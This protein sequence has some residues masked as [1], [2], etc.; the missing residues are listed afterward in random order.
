MARS[1][2]RNQFFSRYKEFISLDRNGKGTK[3][4][5]DDVIKKSRG[6]VRTVAKDTTLRAPELTAAAQKG[7]E[8]NKAKRDPASGV[9]GLSVRITPGAATEAEK[10]ILRA[11]EALKAGGHNG[12]M[13]TQSHEPSARP[14][15]SIIGLEPLLKKA[16]GSMAQVVPEQAMG[17]LL[18]QIRDSV[19]KLIDAAGSDDGLSIDEIIVKPAKTVRDGNGHKAGDDLLTVKAG[20]AGPKVDGGGGRRV[21]NYFPST[22]EVQG[23]VLGMPAFGIGFLCAR[24]TALQSFI[25]G[26]T[27]ASVLNFVRKGFLEKLLPVGDVVFVDTDVSGDAQP[28]LSG[29][30]FAL[31]F[32]RNASGGGGTL[33]IR[34]LDGAA[35]TFAVD[36][37]SLEEKIVE[38]VPTTPENFYTAQEPKADVYDLARLWLEQHDQAAA[39]AARPVRREGHTVGLAAYQD[40]GQK[41][42]GSG[43][44]SMLTSKG[45][46][47]G[48]LMML[49]RTFGTC[50]AQDA[51]LVPG[52]SPE[53]QGRG[54]GDLRGALTS[55]FNGGDGGAPL[56]P[57]APRSMI[58][59]GGFEG[60]DVGNPSVGLENR[61][62][63][64]FHS[65]LLPGL[66]L[67]LDSG[68]VLA[69]S[70][71]E[72]ATMCEGEVCKRITKWLKDPDE[73]WEDSNIYFLGCLIL[74]APVIYAVIAF[75]GPFLAT[76]AAAVG[77][78][79]ASVTLMGW[80]AFLFF[81]PLFLFILFGPKA[82]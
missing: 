79:L 19:F 10:E 68:V 43:L 78:F 21:L 77:G 5:C 61:S 38:V 62:K 37:V 3:A 30:G 28:S 66:F 75:L 74:W 41:R 63:N 9:Q 49:R 4:R 44:I 65:S 8:A 51:D 81:T 46:R 69:S 54:H 25:G 64:R 45:A 42:E 80:V 15:F 22:G 35:M 50:A 11:L 71:L 39:R 6:R 57:T 55:I 76:A 59:G 56:Q 53:R 26:T 17:A 34:S 18:N 58:R 23:F 24:M 82:N 72:L 2:N 27:A 48:L 40:A 33:T 7:K 36:D 70:A 73:E 14:P 13:A 29:K 60:L 47:T 12:P 16:A 67:E 20:K 52:I 1:S 32:S 31:L